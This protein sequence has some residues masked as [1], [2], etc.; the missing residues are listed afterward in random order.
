MGTRIM[1]KAGYNPIEMAR[2]FEKLEAGS[3]KET[4]MT[5]FLSDHPNPGNRVK[6]VE[7]EIRLLPQ[8]SYRKDS[9]ELGRVKSSIAQL[10]EVK[11][12]Q[13]TGPVAG[14]DANNPSAARPSSRLKDLNSKDVYFQYPGNW[15]IHE[16]RQ[17]GEVQITSPAGVV[18]NGI[19]YG[20]LANV[21]QLRQS[22]GDLANQTNDLIKS[23]QQRDSNIRQAGQGKR[24]NVNGVEAMA[25]RLES[26]S[27]FQGTK[28][29]DILVTAL[30][31]K[32]L[33]YLMLIAPERELNNAQPVFD[34]II[35]SIRFLN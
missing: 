6:A 30:R 33:F 2:F 32:G 27:P 17:S 9:G 24:F 7:D 34:A 12:P 5:N 29:V 8:T 20:M 26:Q 16:D 21:V 35:N 10:P 13:Q 3:G 25:M 23:F 19:G 28:E 15:Q 1:N 4:W 14:G 11:K 22:E 31:P 18:G